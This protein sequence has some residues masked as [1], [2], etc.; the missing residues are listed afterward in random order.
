MTDP[1]LLHATLFHSAW[2]LATLQG[3]PATPEVMYHRAESIRLL[4]KSLQSPH[5][6]VPTD[7]TIAAVACLTQF[8][9]PVQTP[10]FLLHD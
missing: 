2:S 10:F 3:R 8:E 5:D 1:A 7:S 4:N 9:V 6:T